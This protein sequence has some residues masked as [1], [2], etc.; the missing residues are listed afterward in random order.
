MP[1]RA[2]GELAIETPAWELDE[3]ACPQPPFHCTV[4]FTCVVAV[5]DPLVAVTVTV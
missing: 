4:R 5:I 2:A 3:A 1:F